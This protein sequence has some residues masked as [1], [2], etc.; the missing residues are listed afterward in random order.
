MLGGAPHVLSP[1]GWRGSPNEAQPAP[2]SISHEVAPPPSPL[3]VGGVRGVWGWREGGG[4]DF[5][6]TVCPL[7]NPP[8]PPSHRVT[9]QR[10]A[11]AAASPFEGTLI[12]LTGGDKQLFDSASPA[13]DVMGK[14][15]FFLGEVCVCV[16]RLWGSRPSFEGAVPR[17]RGAADV[18]SPDPPHPRPAPSPYQTPPSPP[19]PPSHQCWSRQTPAWT[20]SVPLDAPGQ[21]HGQQPRLR[22]S[23]PPRERLA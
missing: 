9:Q 13:L 4:S 8:V 5:V 12:F 1:E 22:D 15:K 16:L 2:S 23:R 10:R 20:R 14:A 6:Q 7:Q 19:P 3:E 21:R 18:F 11:F 17:G